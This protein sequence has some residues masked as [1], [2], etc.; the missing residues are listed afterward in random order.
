MGIIKVN[1]SFLVAIVGLLAISAF[2]EFYYLNF[3][4]PKYSY[5]GFILD[6]N[7]F[8]YIE[9]KLWFIIL[10]FISLVI[11]NRSQFISA[12]FLFLLMLIYV[13]GYIMYS[14]S[15][16]LTPVFYST[17]TFFMIVA[18]IAPLKIKLK[19]VRIPENISYYFLIIFT[20]LLVL[21]VF[22][23]FRFN[24]NTNVLMLD[25]IYDVR[26][27]LKENI[28]FISSYTFWWLAKVILPVLLVYGLLKKDNKI[29]LFS[30]IILLYLFLISGHKSVYFTPILILF[31]FYFGKDYN[32]KILLT[33]GFILVLFVM[34]NLPDFYIGR[35]L[36]KSIFVRRMFFVPAHLNECYFDFFNH[37]HIYLSNSVMSNFIDYP[38]DLQPEYLIGREYFDKPEMS[39][40]AGLI[41]NGFMNFGYIGVVAY[42]VIFSF[43]LMLINSINL[44]K[45]YFGLFIFFM[46]IFRGSPFL[47]TILT[48]GFWLVLVLAFTVLPQ[49]KL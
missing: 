4:C 2:L 45:R 42:S 14:Y 18:I 37:N 46:F 25:D 11:N 43:F 27:V 3:I 29:V 34:I 36:F 21:P 6:F 49:R 16:G 24:I 28:S 40:N 30:L 38:Y 7:W 10:I 12:I 39:S 1:K 35:P 22:N 33:M 48:H 47:T 26:G 9:T 13:P 44:N 41:A 31:Y 17:I 32:E 15:N 23:D 5:S 8:K 20:F 19:V